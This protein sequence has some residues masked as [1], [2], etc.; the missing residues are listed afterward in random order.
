MIAGTLEPKSGEAEMRGIE[1][2]FRSLFENSNDAVLLSTTKGI[3][4]AAN[5]EACRL[6]GRA[7]EEIRRIDRDALVDP[8]DTRLEVLLK[9]QEQAGRFTGELNFRRKDGSV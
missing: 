3:I 7:E 2:Q 8:S 9:E 4:E 1:D 5:P 6:F